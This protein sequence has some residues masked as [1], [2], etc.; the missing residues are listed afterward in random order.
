[1]NRR[2]FL[3]SAAAFAQ[4]KPQ[5][6]PNILF[7]MP[8]QWRGMDLGSMG[9]TQVRT[10]NLDRLAREGVQFR[11]AVANTPVCARARVLLTEISTPAAF[12]Q[13]CFMPAEKTM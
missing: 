11:N 1:M 10:P 7:I 13:R 5:A 3:Q 12:C 4:R 9:N 8:D 6:P 2:L